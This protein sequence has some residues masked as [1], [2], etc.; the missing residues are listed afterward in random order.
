MTVVR[1]LTAKHMDAAN[2]PSWKIHKAAKSFVLQEQMTIAKT[3][4]TAG[5]SEIV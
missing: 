2:A 5:R 3:R 1:A 4:Q